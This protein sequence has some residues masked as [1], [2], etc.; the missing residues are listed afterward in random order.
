MGK[1]GDEASEEMAATRRSR[2]EQDCGRTIAQWT[3]K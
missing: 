2:D 1:E 3:T